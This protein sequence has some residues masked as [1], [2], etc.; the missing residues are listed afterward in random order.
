[1]LSQMD[2]VDV[3][4]NSALMPAEI[5]EFEADAVVIA[6]GSRWRRDGLG[7]T[8]RYPVP[9]DDSAAILT[10]DDVFAGVEIRN[11]VLIY[12][13]EHYMMAGALAEKFLLTGC[14]VKYLTPATTISSWTAMT[15]EQEFI[16]TRLLS[17]GVE[18]VFA[19]KIN[20]VTQGILTTSCIYSGQISEHETD[21]LLLV[22]GRKPNDE[23]Y[24]ELSIDT[25]RIGDCL[26][27]SSIA[28]AV[29]SGHK[30]AREYGENPA[31]LVAKRERAMIQT[32]LTQTNPG[33]IS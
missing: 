27:P 11:E 3:Y 1:M 4:L 21:N 24:R 19:Q 2:N 9:I 33:T 31:R 32:N 13:D 12:D 25:V 22:T 15:D 6:T 29:Y 16:Q 23:L 20:R 8:V 17:L 18:V 14:R 26:V 7:A 5:E 28:D 10:P 30:F